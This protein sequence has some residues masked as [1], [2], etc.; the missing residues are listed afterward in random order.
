MP[1]AA[2]SIYLNSFKDSGG[3]F[4]YGRS[5]SIPVLSVISFS[6]LS[7]EIADTWVIPFVSSGYSHAK[8]I[9]MDSA[10]LIE[11]TFVYLQQE[12]RVG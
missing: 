5:E 10:V 6:H 12:Y 4:F 1:A 9:P 8:C 3:Y 7:L 11:G 2:R